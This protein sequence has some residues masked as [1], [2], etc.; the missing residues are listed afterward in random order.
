MEVT[1]YEYFVRS[2][3]TQL[4]LERNMSEHRMNLDLDKSGSYIR[5][6]TSSASLS[7]LRELF[8]IMD[9]FDLT[10]PEF[11]E[12]LSGGEDLRSKLAEQ[13]RSLDTVGLEKVQTFLQW[14]KP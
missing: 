12:P 2:R 13:L 1:Q 3:I 6:I 4:R 5:N 7:F 10:P 8:R 11:S 14:L 9:Y